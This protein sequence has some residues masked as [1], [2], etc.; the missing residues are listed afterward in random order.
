MKR[1][2]SDIPRNAKERVV[3]AYREKRNEAKNAWVG[4]G[5]MIWLETRECIVGR[6]VVGQRCYNAQGKLEIETPLKNGKKHGR[7]LTWDVDGSLLLVEPY[8]N[9]KI[10]GTAK[11]YDRRGRIVGTS[12]LVHGTGYDIWRNQIGDGPVYVSEIHSMR[13][14]SPHGYEWWLNEDQRSV[15]EE[16]HWYNGQ[17]HGVE[18][19]W[20]Y[21]GKLRRG[22][23]RYWI[24]GEQVGKRKYVLAARKDPT[25]PPFN[26]KDNS[27]RRRFP[28]E[29]Q[30]LLRSIEPRKPPYR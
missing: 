6:K 12:T 20:S 26:V 13:D 29:I 5:T 8:F 18:R 30:K 19:E 17:Y 16:K 2:K 14:G 7:E 10:H 24:H 4:P 15:S 1:L 21:E 28:P 23:P 27:P 11:Q 25:L 9:G 22:Y 3:R